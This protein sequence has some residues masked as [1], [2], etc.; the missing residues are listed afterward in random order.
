VRIAPTATALYVL[1]Q[2]AGPPSTDDWAFWI[3]FDFM[4]EQF[5][6]VELAI[7]HSGNDHLT[8]APEDGCTAPRPTTA[9]WRGSTRR[10]RSAAHNLADNLS[11]DQPILA[12][13]A[14]TV[15][16]VASANPDLPIGQYGDPNDANFLFLG[17][18][19]EHRPPV[20]RT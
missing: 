9:R 14:G 13:A 18:S 15:S 5:D 19:G 3:R 20:S 1:I 2:T 11:F 8:Y 17:D 7:N 4:G 12:P 10:S 6:D 16:S